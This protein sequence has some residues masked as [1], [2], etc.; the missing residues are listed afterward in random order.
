MYEGGLAE[1]YVQALTKEIARWSE[2]KSPVAVDTIYFGG[3]TPSLLTPPQIERILRAVTDRFDVLN[4]GEITIEL[5]PGDGGTSTTSK[6]GTLRE[7]RRLGINRASFGA[8]TFDD[9]ELKQLG[10]RHTAADI[11][12][13]E[14]F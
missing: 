6:H 8:Q 14:L 12:A 11:P 2:V 4:G 13:T 7:F 1:R 10:R 5:N 3:G 9:R